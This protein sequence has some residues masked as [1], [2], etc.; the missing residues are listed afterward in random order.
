MVPA[1]ALLVVWKEDIWCFAALLD[2]IF[3]ACGCGAALFRIIAF[4]ICRIAAI[5][6]GAARVYIIV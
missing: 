1:T 6:I 2:V 3:K 4:V 5:C